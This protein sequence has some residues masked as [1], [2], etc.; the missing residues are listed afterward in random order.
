M[1]AE[2]N[3]KELVTW[4][5]EQCLA[6]SIL[7]KDK[8]VQLLDIEP[9]SRDDLVLRKT[10]DEVAKTITGGEG[11]IWCAVGM[12]YMCCGM[13]CSFCSFG[14]KWNVIKDSRFV[15]EKEVMESARRYAEGGASY[16]ILR[17]TES[18]DF[19]SLLEYV[20]RIR[21][22][23]PGDYE[24]VLNTCEIDAGMAE[25]AYQAGVY[26]VYHALRLREGTDT[27]FDPVHRK[28]AM[29]IIQ[30]SPPGADQPHGTHRPGTQQRGDRGLLFEYGGARRDHGRPDGQDPG[31]G[32]TAGGFEAADG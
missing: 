10:A 26:G 6:G 18:F 14:E 2:I 32:N 15:T 21:R 5:R 4:A 23:I 25:R 11:G 7:P 28:E 9:G 19:N 17:T 13:N 22:E 31:P 20:P 27:P 1:C 8:I 30:D 16:I 24:I 3:N 29:K 12:D